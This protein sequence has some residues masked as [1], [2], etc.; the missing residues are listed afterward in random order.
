MTVK[1]SRD[2]PLSVSVIVP[3]LDEQPRIAGLLTRLRAMSPEQVVVVDGGSTDAT[4][5]VAAPL[6]DHLIGSRPGRARQMNAG[7]AVATEEVLWFV[8]ADSVV[9]GDA[10]QQIREA[11]AVG[12]DWGRFDV[13]LSGDRVLYRVVAWCMNRRSRLTGICTGDQ[14]LFVRRE[15]FERAGG[16]PDQ[17]LMEDIALCRALKALGPPACAPGPLVT[18]S[19]RWETR[20]AWRTI[21]LMWR[22]RLAY[23]LGCSPERLHRH[24]YGEKRR[25]AR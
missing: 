8:H 13:R 5:A 16:Y 21:L 11:L 10:L 14:G 4:A 25:S 17:P 18:S 7:A 22:L 19:R 20:G 2:A 23:A 9:P 3:V 15:A 1:P 24:Y 12:A 6:C